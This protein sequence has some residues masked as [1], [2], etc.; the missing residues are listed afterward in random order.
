[1]PD[2]TSTAA[3]A[4]FLTINLPQDNQNGP[5]VM[6]HVLSSLHGL[7]TPVS[8][9]IWSDPTCIQLA[10]VC[11]NQHKP[12]VIN[13]LESHYPGIAIL[14]TADLVGRL[15]HLRTAYLKLNTIPIFPIRRYAQTADTI[16][17]TWSDPY[18]GIIAAIKTAAAT[19][20]LQIVITA[21]PPSWRKHGTDTFA[22]YEAISAWWLLKRWWRLKKLIITIVYR[23]SLVRMILLLFIS[24]PAAHAPQKID[25]R[26]H[27]QESTADAVR[28]KL[29][30]LAFSVTIKFIGEPVS[31]PITVQELGSSFSQF[32]IA[33]LNGFSIR[34]VSTRITRDNGEVA[35][36]L[37][38]YPMMLSIEELAGML[39][40]PTNDVKTPELMRTPFRVMPY[41]PNFGDSDGVVIGTS[42]CQ[43][44]RVPVRLTR[45]ILKAHLPILGK[46]GSGKSTFMRNVLQALLETGQGVGLLDPHGDLLDAM[47]HLIPDHRAGNVVLIDPTDTDYPI[48]FNVLKSAAGKRHQVISAVVDTFHTLFAESWGPR[49]EYVLSHAVAALSYVP[50]ASLLGL[51]KLLL[52]TRYRNECLKYLQDPLL[53]GFWENEYKTM[54]ARLRMETITPI[55]NKV[56]RFLMVPLMRNILGQQENRIS[57]RAIMDNQQVLLINLAKGI[58]GEENSRLLGNFFL[59]HL[60]IAALNRADSSSEQRRQFTVFVDE[61]QHFA[62]LNSSHIATILA[63]GRKYR[64]NLILACQHISQLRDLAATLFGN[65]NTLVA[66][67]VG[68]DDALKISAYL[69]DVTPTD[70]IGL[71][72]H[73][74][75]VRFTQGTTPRVVSFQN[76]LA[77]LKTP[78]T[79][80]KDQVRNH[81]RQ[82]FARPRI[83]VEAEISRFFRTY[84]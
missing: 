37:I 71:P 23:S 11:Q 34:P 41:V 79:S 29:A 76:I 5:M 8:F 67:S 66:F 50:G 58:L 14:E 2:Q 46:T 42:F 53:T 65:M 18:V 84:L 62:G 40:L 47:L 39:A 31:M 83:E 77:D 12:F 16:N 3:A 69:G 19:R 32:S 55:L 30:Q 81:S 82:T 72:A 43:G 25:H 73:C 45:K 49:T 59:S 4:C 13:Q 63:E 80:L 60:Q 36:R 48:A 57:L 1:M 44:T 27:F 28:S 22:I 68:Y 51:P 64:V 6:E 74:A 17:R 26:G 21:A 52:E 20:G 78:L 24:K 9:E 38:R 10:V 56:N 61:L 75:Y 70:L 54:P 33:E 15:P 7:K 35:K